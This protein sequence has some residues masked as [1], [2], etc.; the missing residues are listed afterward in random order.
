MGRY[1]WKTPAAEEED[2][3]KTVS[4]KS[5]GNDDA[6]KANE[7]GRYL[8][9]SSGCGEVSKHDDFSRYLRKTSASDYD[10]VASH[11]NDVMKVDD[12][13]RYS[14]KPSASDYDKVSSSSNDVA[15]KENLSW[16]SRKPSDC[17]KLSGNSGDASKADVEHRK[18]SNGHHRDDDDYDFKSKDYDRRRHSA[19][20]GHS[21]SLDQVGKQSDRK[22]FETKYQKWSKSKPNYANPTRIIIL[23]IPGSF[24]FCLFSRHHSSERQRFP[25][26]SLLFADC[27]K[28]LQELNQK[29]SIVHNLVQ[30]LLY[31]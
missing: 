6:T 2:V 17:D 29:I 18:T 31:L 16:Y 25:K 22:V 13:Y 1:T 10:K 5:S 9:K 15:K 8:R 11:A 12:K 20:G 3:I 30:N 14:R 26:I 28:M 4:R 19:P 24:D 7:V 21:D 27:P 23:K